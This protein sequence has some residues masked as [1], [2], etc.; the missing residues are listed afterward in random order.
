[1]RFSTCRGGYRLPSLISM[2][3]IL[4]C[5]DVT[6]FVYPR[7]TSS[8]ARL[9]LVERPPVQFHRGHTQRRSG[10]H[11]IVLKVVVENEKDPT[12]VWPK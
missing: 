12:E 10:T 2:Y 5:I 9:R 6:G 4:Q 11:G 1:M 7:T 8:L 3:R